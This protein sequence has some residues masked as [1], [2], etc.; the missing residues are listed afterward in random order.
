MTDVAALQAA[1]QT[2]E[3]AK[4]VLLEE[5]R[6]NRETMSRIDFR[7]YNEATKTQQID[8]Q[9]TIDSTTAEF[10]KALNEV[11]ADAVAQVIDVGTLTESNTPGGANG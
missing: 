10:Q 5:R 8:T 11:R 2:A 4:E 6:T 9:A 1:V 3:A 7:A